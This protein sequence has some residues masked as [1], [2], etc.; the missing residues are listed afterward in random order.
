MYVEFDDTSDV[1][2]CKSGNRLE[3][4]ACNI[5]G[6]SFYANSTD[7][8]CGHLEKHRKNGDR[9]PDDLE[10]RLWNDDEFNFPYE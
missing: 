6:G 4:L 2:V 8:M 7:T 5:S 3:C 1:Y 9:I 10:D